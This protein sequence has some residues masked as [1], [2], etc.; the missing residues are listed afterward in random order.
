MVLV[1]V[2][3]GMLLAVYGHFASKRAEL[4]DARAELRSVAKLASAS[5]AQTIEGV[6]QI[7]ST[8][9]AGPSVR[10]D[11][12][13][14]LC[15]EYL[16]NIGQASPGYGNIGVVDLNGDVRCQGHPDNVKFNMADRQ[17]F[18][19]ALSDQRFSVGEYLLGKV[20]GSP[21]LGFGMPVYTY[22]GELRGVAFAT[23]DLRRANQ[24]LQA[25]GLPR[26]LQVVVVDA[27]G[28][29]LLSSAGAEQ[30]IGKTVPN[31]ELA[32][33]IRAAR[34]DRVDTTDGHGTAWLHEL[35][36]VADVGGAGL[37]VV[38]SARRDEILGPAGQRL[39]RELAVLAASTGLGLLLAWLLSV[40]QIADPVSR[41]LQ[42]MQDA[43]LDKPMAPRNEQSTSKEFDDLEEGFED[44]LQRLHSNQEQLAKAQ[45]IARLGFY[46]LDLRTRMYTASATVYDML[47]L[48]P[49]QG[50]VTVEQYQG[51]LHPDD[52]ALVNTHRDR[53]FAGG[54]PLR[55]QYRVVRPDGQIR[56][57]D[58]FGFVDRDAA[59]NPTIY[60][61]ALQD[62]TDQ[63]RLR[64]LF[65]VQ[66]EINAAIVRTTSALD[67]YERA[68]QIAVQD[69]GMRMAWVATVDAATNVV[70]PFVHAGSE[71]GYLTLV[72]RT[73]IDVQNHGAPVPTAL[74]T[75][76]L[77]VCND[78]AT[79]ARMG[80]WRDGAIRRGY[81]SAAAVP[82]CVEGKAVAALAFMAG[83]PN[84]FQDEERELLRAIGESL[85]LAM[86]NFD[87]EARRR[88]AE[89]QLKLLETCVARL[90]DVVLI[91][92]A[93]PFDEPGPRILYVNDAF[94]RR[95]GY[96]RAEA[97]G[98]TP[99]MLQGPRT[100]RDALDR[101]HASLKRWEPVREELINYTKTGEEFW[102]ELEIVPVANEVGW[103][104]HW[105]AIERDI[106]ERKHAEQK[107][108]QLH[109]SFRLLFLGNPHPMWV[110]DVES[111]AFLEVNAA[112]IDQY[113]YSREEFLT[114]TIND[115]RPEEERQRLRARLFEPPA[116]GRDRAGIWIHQRKSGQLVQVDITTQ[117]LEYLGRQGE[118]VVAMDMTERIAAEAAREEAVRSLSHSQVRLAR[119]Q[120]LARI[121]SWERFA[122]DGSATWSAGLYE[123]TGRDPNLGPTAIEQAVLTV[124]PEDVAEYQATMNACLAEGR[125]RRWSYRFRHPDGRLRWFEETI[126]EPARDDSGAV[127]SVEGTVQ[128]VTERMD[129]ERRLQTQLARTEMLNGIARAID[130]RLDLDSM[131]QVVCES[132]ES[133]FQVEFAA[134]GICEPDSHSLRLVC[135]GSRGASLA[136]ATGLAQGQVLPIGENG[137]SRCVR[138]EL[139]HEPDIG[140]SRFAFPQALSS[141]GL[142][143]LVLAP[144]QADQKVFGVLIVARAAAN[145]FSSG[146][147][148]FV[149][150][151][152]EHVALAASQARLHGDLQRAYDDLRDAQQQVLQTE[153]L[154]VI[155]QMASGIAHDINNAISPVALYTESLLRRERSL[156]ERGREQLQTIQLAI[157][158][159]AET[160]ARMR[161]F[162]RPS[163]AGTR[164][165][166]I[167]V[168]RLVR[169]VVDLTRARWRDIPQQAG[170]SV[171]LVPDLCE[172]LP[173][174]DAAEGELRDALTNLVL[175]AV[176]AMPTG[177]CLTI[178]TARANSE[179]GAALI[180]L[181]VSDTGIGMD[182]E[183]RRRCLEPFF[184]TKGD[185]GS[186]LGL[187]MVYGAVQRHGALMTIGST[188]GQGTRV[189]L[190]FSDPAASALASEPQTVG[191]GAVEGSALRVLV[192]DD[193][194]LLLRSLVEI[195][196]QEGHAV[197]TASGGRPGI[198]VFDAAISSGACFDAVIT[199]L[200]MP[201]VDGRWVAQAVKNRSPETPVVMLTG[202][203]R[204]MEE[205]GERPNG[206][207][208]LMSK[209]PRLAELR[210]VL[211]R[212]R[213]HS[214]RV[215]DS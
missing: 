54:K 115:I 113:G 38:A 131:F 151:L 69:G 53:L 194:A 94:E 88:A 14:G 148:E 212:Y 40:R 185:R 169:Q 95:T 202:W 195:L 52:R 191:G 4:E 33:A 65:A 28:T 214:E 152:G 21:Q 184:T 61:G 109:D 58:G 67:L 12:L 136:A 9:A 162:Y 183:T 117:R 133:Q 145:A 187:A 120:S 35:A 8:V 135:I 50:P 70:V 31:A 96:T 119:A 193:D 175:N 26:H 164:R 186:G 78:I 166:P 116:N 77:A 11:D 34:V 84:H 190:D 90:N 137:L 176:D 1:A 127:I 68:C 197:T 206:V 208:H 17:Y 101:I 147:C 129:A 122:N 27:T 89:A 74:R 73:A 180:R 86:S 82:I 181:E 121:G 81:R 85:S 46:Q 18:R 105:V 143:S 138:G 130:N 207:D 189:R 7:L 45:Q 75:G 173:P 165:R 2:T 49:A 196:E 20:T 42:R 182:E 153:R 66:G 192:I 13:L 79:D 98:N 41:L 132:V 80:V 139:V 10:R 144:L 200:G 112:A 156:S 140:Q 60:A 118:L 154:R 158:D 150:Q 160:V 141:G 126:N 149:R 146:E 199:D 16:R 92:E 63:Q 157:D 201:E 47:G 107:E 56:W 104:T 128:D 171:E 19:S 23:I 43:A 106:T 71:D 24:R 51:M 125:V 83:A 30:G 110:F 37:N 172:G 213:R 22:G 102:L 103:Y 5:Q 211:A 179:T 29:V 91:T 6:R 170:I 76:A 3:P 87:R 114:M 215:S 48:D 124:H 142:G 203:G 62:I 163:E 198:D 57:L 188:V 205:D 123:L 59:G 210:T 155:G 36:T 55:L 99:R 100:Q 161:E 108:A 44:M 39:T 93:E 174:L 32:A 15:I 177:G 167:D 72:R 111:H 97:I 134:A 204:R 168:N 209:P 64:S 159:V 178:K 25:L